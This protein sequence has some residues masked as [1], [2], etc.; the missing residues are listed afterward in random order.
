MEKG[1]KSPLLY[2]QAKRHRVVAGLSWDAREDKVSFVGRIQG[3]TQH[4]L[5]ISAFIYDH[6]GDFIDIVTA[7]ATDA[8]DDSGAI[9]HSGDDQT[10]EGE[11]DDEHISVELAGLPDE[12][13]SIIFVIESRSAHTFG[14]I[15]EINA[16]IADGMSNSD[17]LKTDLNGEDGKDSIGYVF[18]R[19]YPDDGSESGWMLHFIDE[20]PNTDDVEEW[21]AYLKKYLD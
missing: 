6:E 4:D 16:R 21:G 7:E 17:L 3:D 14:H 5:D 19:L 8:I 11:G 13:Q 2:T 15:A 18:A 12:I 20:Y 1:S 10:G 9:Y